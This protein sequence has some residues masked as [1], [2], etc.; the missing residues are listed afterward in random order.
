MK[1]FL[2]AIFMKRGDLWKLIAIACTVSG[3]NFWRDWYCYLI[4]WLHRRM[5]MEW[6]YLYHRLQR[7]Y[8]LSL[9][10]RRRDWFYNYITTSDYFTGIQN[11]IMLN[12]LNWFL[13]IFTDICW[14]I[15]SKEM[16]AF[17][18]NL[19]RYFSLTYHNKSTC[20]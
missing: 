15:P 18:G 13:T 1:T 9:P 4:S 17:K 19:M 11:W 6:P 12:V 3:T 10:R 7:K 20:L 16:Q 8:N 14:R 5:L 2:S